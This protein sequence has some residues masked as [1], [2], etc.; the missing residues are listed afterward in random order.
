MTAFRFSGFNE[1][2]VTQRNG[3]NAAGDEVT[4]G[5]SGVEGAPGSTAT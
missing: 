5:T 2:G 3:V 1:Y 4:V